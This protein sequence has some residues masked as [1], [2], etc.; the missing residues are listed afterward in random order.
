MR[1]PSTRGH[2]LPPRTPPVIDNL[3]AEIGRRS[4]HALHVWYLAAQRALVCDLHR[5]RATVRERR[6]IPGEGA[7]H[8]RV[9]DYL[10]WR[11]GSL[12]AAGALL[13]LA[14]VVKLVRTPTATPDAAL[15]ETI[16][17]LLAAVM[18]LAAAARWPALGWS[19]GLTWGALGIGVGL[20][21]L[22]AILAPGQAMPL[23]AA[24]GLLV[25]LPAALR[26]L[27]TA[28]T[29]FPGRA[30]A[31]AA[32]RATATATAAAMA[33]ACLWASR[34]HA[35]SFAVLCCLGLVLAPMLQG[36]IAGRRLGLARMDSSH[37]SHA[38]RRAR[39][40]S[41]PAYAIGV[42]GMLAVVGSAAAAGTPLF[43]EIARVLGV[44]VLGVAFAADA[45]VVRLLDEWSEQSDWEASDFASDHRSQ[46]GALA[47]LWDR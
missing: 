4:G 42:L 26:G 43:G 39:A 3:P 46:L 32:V 41:L 15:L 24:A 7:A 45:T 44:F 13:L 21:T 37:A 18:V 28:K 29:A 11:R 16:T 33:V 2:P 10:A 5:L 8:H 12:L 47:R 17:T 27:T 36:A 19:R 31:G 6:E 9:V 23:S 14:G 1:P 22:Q 25:L 20:P 38:V 30:Q 35:G 40:W 34:Q